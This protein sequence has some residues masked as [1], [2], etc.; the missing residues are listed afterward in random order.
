M[1]LR[2]TLLGDMTMVD[3]S[4][5]IVVECWNAREES[6]VEKRHLFTRP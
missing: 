1:G 6:E 4:N 3:P 2:E 5:D